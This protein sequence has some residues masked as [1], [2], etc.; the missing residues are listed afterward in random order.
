MK[1]LVILNPRAGRGRARR[2]MPVVRKTL[3]D[4]KV[5][6]DLRLT[7]GPGD[8]TRLASEAVSSGYDVVVAAGGDGTVNEVANGI[9]GSNVILGVIP[10]G[11]GNDFSIGLD[12]PR[13]PA[14]ACQLLMTGRIAHLDVGRVL[15]RFFVS[16]V[17]VGFDA[18]VARQANQSIPLLRGP[19]VYVLA[20]LRVLFTYKAP[21]IKVKLD[22]KELSLES[23][24]VAVTNAPTYGGG[25]KITP[26]AI[27]DDGM[28]EVCVIEKMRS[29]E[30]LF[31]LPKVFTGTHVKVPKV[32]IYRASEVMIEADR[33]IYLHMDGEIASTSRFHFQIKK[34]AL[35]VISGPGARIAFQDDAAWS[36]IGCGVTFDRPRGIASTAARATIL[37]RI[38][39]L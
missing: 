38:G 17:G 19:V 36:G 27:M 35:A 14:K 8:A 29:L 21:R 33:P 2:V 39:T 3:S 37:G 16:S 7:R 13:D 32:K 23:L 5:S 30:T 31:A 9:I 11:T 15:D 12:I 6:F 25:M 28:F 20:L 4:L 26:D 10:C 34:Q 18:T 1:F 24:L 22:H